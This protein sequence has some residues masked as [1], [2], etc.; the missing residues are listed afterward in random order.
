MLWASF[1]R[2]GGACGLSTWAFLL[3]SAWL[4][5]R[6]V[7]REFGT[8]AALF[9]AATFLIYARLLG[10]GGGLTENYALLFQFLALFMFLRAERKGG[11]D[12]RLCLALGVL[13]A[14]SFLLRANLI[15]VW[16]TIGVYWVIRWRETRS[17]I[18]WSVVG[19]VSVLIAVSITFASLGA[20]AEFWGATALFNFAQSA[21]S[22]DD[23]IRAAMLLVWHLSPVLPLLG[24]GW[25]VGIW[26]YLTGK[27]QGQTFE[28]IWPFALTLG[29]V[30]VTLTLLSGNGFDHYFLPILP[31]GTLY[32][33]FLVWLVSKERLATPAF[34]TFI[35]L[36]IT[37]NYHMDVYD[38]AFEIVRMVRSTGDQSSIIGRERDLRVAEAVKQNSRAE[39]TILVW[40]TQPQIYLLTGRDS[41]TRF[42]YQYPLIKPGY[43]RES[44]LDEF[45]SDVTSGHPTVI[46]DSRNPRLPPLDEAS[47]SD[48][49]AQRRYLHDPTVFQWLFDLV[50][51]EYDLI[52]D[53]D[54]FRVYA[55][56]GSE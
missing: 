31:V 3:G 9:S 28:R 52:E 43:T 11:P 1:F 33:G 53:I 21:A 51:A 12:A 50:E 54:G 26:Y 24:V 30:E 15:G 46:I 40:G 4:A 17:R 47:R 5:F 55:R 16:L 23:R 32:L 34:L 7:Q 41:P 6:M 25:C 22:V 42:F 13:G 19:G 44:D 38:K 2:G 10:K 27:M 49:Q 37:A 35:L 8:T 56:T 45:I 36:F 20:W 48:W 14:L 18:A 29:P 39:D